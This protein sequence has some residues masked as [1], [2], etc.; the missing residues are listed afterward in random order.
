MTRG[1]LTLT[2]VFLTAC[3]TPPAADVQPELSQTQRAY[4]DRVRKNFPNIELVT[5]HG[6]HVRFYD[7]LIKDRVV[8]IYFMFT[9]CEGICPATTTN[10]ARMQDILGDR[11]GQDVFGAHRPALSSGASGECRRHRNR[12]RRGG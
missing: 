9:T 1:V 6:E 4:R 10:V 11:F 2:C 5:Q 7:D 3:A 12:R 8:L